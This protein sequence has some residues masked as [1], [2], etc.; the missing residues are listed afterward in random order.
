MGYLKGRHD[1]N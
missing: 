1:I